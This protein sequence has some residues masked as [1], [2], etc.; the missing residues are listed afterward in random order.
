MRFTFPLLA[1]VLVVMIGACQYTQKIR[2]GK[3]AYER[4]QFSVAVPMLEK[5]YKKADTRLEKGKLAFLLGESYKELNQSPQSIEWYRIAYDNQYGVDALKEYAYSLKRNEQY[6]EAIKA[7]KELGIEIGSPYEYKREINACEIAAG[8]KRIKQPEYS[9]ELEPFNSGKSDYA[10]SLYRDNQLVFS[11]DRSG[12]TGDD[13]YKWTG[14]AFSDLYVVDLKSN[15]IS[16]FDKIINSADNEGTVAF[17]KDFKEVYFTR[18][19]NADKR[20]DAYCKIMVSENRGNSWSP[21]RVLPFIE[22]QINYGH[23]SLSENG[24]QLY[25]SANHPDGWGGFDIYVSERQADGEWGTPQLLNRNINTPGNERFPFIDHDT[26]YF[27]SDYHPG[28]G[29]LDIFRANKLSNGAWTPV[30]NLKPPINSGADDFGFVIDY[31][32]PLTSGVLQQGYF[33]STRDNGAGND[34]I[35][36]FEKRIPPPVVEDPNRPTKPV[37]YKMI[38]DGYVLEKIYEQP[39]NPNSRVLGRKPLDAAVVEIKLGKEKKNVTVGEDGH[40]SLELADNTDYDFVAAKQGYLSNKTDFT[41]RGLGKDPS[42][43]EM[44]YELEIV[45]DKIYFGQEIVLE[46]IYYDFD[47][48]D[49]RPDA[50]PTLNKLAENLQLNPD[51]RIQLSSHTDCRGNDRY[52]EE[53]SQKRA[54]SAVEY[55]ISKGVDRNRLVAKGYGEGVPAVNCLC[56]RCSEE[57][58][59]ANRRTTFKIIE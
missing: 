35:Y 16:S 24:K 41:T 5:E 49:I 2:D 47:K 12:S 50:Q 27:A 8:W 40:F 29:G 54:E 10:P 44:H 31:S 38:L 11:S 18:C 48:W 58:H 30:F 52:N 21:P 1:I 51:V 55:L 4:K 42:N 32:K 59:Q 13:T 9:V 26:L 53:L 20:E 6:E 23:P 37:V 15:T 43:P 3:T 19:Y 33:S 14:N 17:S 57:E 28:M 7:F 46:N 34:D 22:D 56:A 45:L 25:F 39:G 36:K